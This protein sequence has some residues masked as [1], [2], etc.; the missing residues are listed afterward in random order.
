[1]IEIVFILLGIL[2]VFL[3]V[4]S[5]IKAKRKASQGGCGCKISHNN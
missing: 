4:R 1:M 2:G 5:F 3:G